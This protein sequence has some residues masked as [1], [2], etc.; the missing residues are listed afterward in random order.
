[1]TNGVPPWMPQQPR[2]PP[3]PEEYYAPG[4]SAPPEYNRDAARHIYQAHPSRRQFVANYLAN[5]NRP[6]PRRTNDQLRE[7]LPPDQQGYQFGLPPG[8]P[9]TL[10]G[11][12]ASFMGNPLVQAA[13]LALPGAA[14]G[15]AIAPGIGTV[16]GGGIG[17]AAGLVLPRYQQDTMEQLAAQYGWAEAQ[18]RFDNENPV[19][20]A[21]RLLNVPF[22]FLE[23][24][25]GTAAQ[26]GGS[27]LAPDQYGKFDESFGN[28][29]NTWDAARLTYEATPIFP[30]AN[31][32]LQPEGRTFVD[33]DLPETNGGLMALVEARRRLAAG[34]DR[35]MVLADMSAR[36]GAPG[37]LRELAAG[38]LADPLNAAPNI[39]TGLIKYGARLAGA[40]DLARAA[41]AT[42]QGG[43]VGTLQNYRNLLV[44]ERAFRSGFESSRDLNLLQRALVGRTLTGLAEGGTY[45]P[46]KWWEQWKLSPES[47]A[48]ELVF[49]TSNHVQSALSN[50]PVDDTYPAR[51]SALL[52][53][54]RTADLDN[55]PS[56]IDNIAT[57]IEGRVVRRSL[58]ENIG[59]DHAAAWEAT[60]P[61]RTNL[62][63]L[64]EAVGDTP[65]NVL[66]RIGAGE[67]D[68][69]LRAAGIEDITPAQLE[70]M[71]GAFVDDGV[72]YT[73]EMARA[74]IMSGLVEASGKWAAE[75]FGLKS[76]GFLRKLAGAVKGVESVAL[77]GL[78]ITYPVRNFLNG[79]A[80]MAARGA[81][82]LRGPGAVMRDLERMGLSPARLRSGLGI[83]DIGD[84]FGGQSI[85][86]GLKPIQE[87]TRATDQGFT[88][89]ILNTIET[90]AGDIASMLPPTKIA[91]DVERWQSVRA[92]GEGVRQMWSQAWRPGV[93]FDKLP[94]QLEQALRAYDA[95]LPGHIYAAIQSGFSPAEI[96]ARVLADAPEIQLASFYDDVARATG[97]APET[98]G[99]LM[100]VEGL[101]DYL[102]TELAKL[103]AR[104]TADDVGRVFRRSRERVERSLTKLASEDTAARLEHAA[105]VAQAE[106]P[107]GALRVLDDVEEQLYQTYQNHMQ[108]LALEWDEVRRARQF[109]DTIFSRMRE[110]ADQTWRRYFAYEDSVYK[111]VEQGL[112]S[113]NWSVGAEFLESIRSRREMVRAFHQSKNELLT[114]FF[115]GKHNDDAARAAAWADTTARID[116]LYTRLTGDVD[117]LSATADRAL[118]DVFARN[119]GDAAATRVETWRNAIRRFNREDMQGQQAFRQTLQGLDPAQRN[120]A[121]RSFSDQRLQRRRVML[122]EAL[123]LQRQVVDERVLQGAQA[124]PPPATP[125]VRVPGDPGPTPGLNPEG[126]DAAGRETVY[127]GP[128]GLSTSE[129][130]RWMVQQDPSFGLPAGSSPPSPVP[131]APAPV[132]PPPV[133]PVVNPAAR[134]ARDE[135]FAL[136]NEQGINTVAANGAPNNRFLLN[137]LNKY[138]DADV[139]T[140][141][142][143]EVAGAGMDELRLAQARDALT[144]RQLTQAAEA[145]WKAS[146]SQQAPGNLDVADVTGSFRHELP[147][148]LSESL[149]TTARVMMDELLQGEPGRRLFNYDVEGQGGSPVVTSSP[150][151]YP[152]WYGPF[153]EEYK[154]N[155]AA[156][157]KA[158]DKIIEDAGKDKGVMV[159]RLKRQ[160]LE[161]MAE[162]V[163]GMPPDPDALRILGKGLDEITAAEE[164]WR[165][166]GEDPGQPGSPPV[167]NSPDPV[168]PGPV[169]PLIADAPEGQA[170]MFTGGEELPLFSGTV[171]RATE[172][173]FTPTERPGVQGQMPGMETRP[174]MAGP[175]RVDPEIA[176]LEESLA[177]A[178]A[179][180]QR[181]RPEA[182]AERDAGSTVGRASQKLADAERRQKAI[183]LQLAQAKKGRI[184]NA[185]DDTSKDVP[186]IDSAPNGF[187]G[188]PPGTIDSLT[189]GGP[190][191]L[192]QA[193]EEAWYSYMLPVMEELQ[194]RAEA[195]TGELP[196]AGHGQLPPDLQ[197]GVRSYLRDVQGRMPAAK[198]QAVK[199]GEFKRDAALLNYSRRFQFNNALGMVAPYE[200]WMTNSL[201]KW[202]LHSL[203]RPA[204]LANYYRVQKFLN[205]QVGRPGH[206]SRLAG[207][208]KIPLPFMPDWMG[209]GVW[210]NPTQI[211]LPLDQFFNIPEQIQQATLSRSRG[212]ERKLRE[213]VENGQITQAQADEAMATQ[214]GPAWDRATQLA[215]SDDANLKFDAVDMGSL[216][217]S[218]HL[219]LSWAYNALRGTPERIGPLPLTRQV[220]NLT[221]ALG[222]GGP[223]G[224]NLEEG[225]RRKLGLPVF[226]QWEDYRIDR[227]LSDMAA[228]G[229]ITA[230]QAQAAMIERSGP[231]F[232]AAEQ[233][234]AVQASGG[235]GG[236]VFSN[237][238]GIPVGTL[239]EGEE[240]QRILALLNSAAYDARENGDTE[241]L[242]RFY[243]QYPEYSARM[244]LYDDKD[245]RIRSFLV[246]SVWTAYNGLPDLYRREVSEQFG[247]EFQDGFLDRDTRDYDGLA[248]DTLA[249]WARA[250]GRYVPAN[251][252]GEAVPLAL[253]PPEVAAKAQEF[254]ARRNA[255]MTPALR[256]TQDAYFDIAQGDRVNVAPPDVVAYYDEKDERWPDINALQE[257]YFSLPEGSRAR[258]QYR[259]QN[260]QLTEY[261]DW[262]RQWREANP[263]AT[264]YIDSDAPITRSRR[265]I[266][267][268]SHPE[269]AQYWDW[270]RA[271]LDTNPDIAPYVTEQAQAQPQAAA[272]VE[273]APDVQRQVVGYLYANRSLPPSVER[274][275]MA[276]WQQAGQPGRF[277]EWLMSVMQGSQ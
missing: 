242:E 24:G 88:S 244:A 18:R 115:T 123:K 247:A 137:V 218:P 141:T 170:P 61:D 28:L 245:E 238:A 110:R 5:L 161:E 85:A 98:V 94:P 277:E 274:Q 143:D 254:Y 212:A 202:A 190:V 105:T 7:Q 223:G 107:A 80:T 199:W 54:Y 179:E 31:G 163:W 33:Y 195:A 233:R 153:L 21:L 9:D 230:E 151:T 206:P 73:P 12:L 41:S 108:A 167:F 16:I 188:L 100:A 127:S 25:V 236:Q 145:D 156:V 259:E 268:D 34:E 6:R 160:I 22:Q 201:I 89:R 271:W 47:E 62:L 175:I 55:L 42:P 191:P 104:P 197:A 149:F 235:V 135:L 39:E 122:E 1:M 186:G 109:K 3:E 217:A 261:W 136:A 50:L 198:L 77:L 63:R 40:T 130:V 239:P 257:A 231:L 43:L 126:Y 150:S 221:A 113:G 97:V 228:E 70:Q 13:T 51:A 14:L 128:P 102:D 240:R 138:K 60:T 157:I 57:S 184:G 69:L 243:D 86:A 4:G 249:G 147:T 65:P 168:D 248:P 116:G 267:L 275:L 11:R 224:V 263:E 26:L 173:A 252:E 172:E 75:T 203:D 93:G 178:R 210:V 121:W 241:A 214:G 164:A 225:L 215:L 226:D 27:A 78:N 265:S 17:A 118:T 204:L 269:L 216:V 176:R 181:L 182:K 119:L 38:F 262:R 114:Q 125:V 53:A 196:I 205:T 177:N 19:G 237:I 260:P 48:R 20:I 192:A 58:P 194:K 222:M 162:G 96:A 183:S 158:L 56:G 134:L 258:R 234:S 185:A 79:E 92:M 106:G 169:P 35:E 213:L 95:R 81:W 209:G 32:W 99:R 255:L 250:L 74:A 15:T 129:Q 227:S 68:A 90:K 84:E 152:D 82:G 251:V 273:L 166:L 111:G 131:N 45:T 64:A 72:P 276:E 272:A 133:A 187:I 159:Q 142:L 200:F 132:A 140:F 76:P 59:R 103:P 229:L 49:Q 208:V 220:R 219:P 36:F 264:A 148:K 2:R 174:E 10:R 120:L 246:D 23:Q 101:G 52:E 180:V 144:M 266:Y 46:P 44:S 30:S 66:A 193:Q 165:L 146:L 232:E 189:D 29:R 91:Q 139:P 87:A 124:V 155:R 117:G 8:G 270:R 71:R 67:G 154:T 83:A 37:Q 256:R 211:G 171:Q 207:R 253:A 112:R